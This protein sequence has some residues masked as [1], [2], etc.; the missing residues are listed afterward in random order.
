MYEVNFFIYIN[1]KYFNTAKTL[2]LELHKY[3]FGVF[4][5]KHQIHDVN[6]HKE[7]CK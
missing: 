3:L 5:T 4:R 1:Y 2:E 7:Y 6:L